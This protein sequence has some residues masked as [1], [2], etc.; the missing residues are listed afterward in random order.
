MAN[1][2]GLEPVNSLVTEKA[3]KTY[4]FPTSANHGASEADTAS[5]ATVGDGDFRE[6]SQSWDAK[7]SGG[8]A[9]ATAKEKL[10]DM[11]SVVVKNYR[12]ASDTTDDFV[13]DNPWKAIVMAGLGG[14][15]VGMLVS[16]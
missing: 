13:H 6:A 2:D 7:S 9:R 14:L 16:R 15:I 11:K 5:S 10:A 12:A 8:E 1:T 4:E 3:D